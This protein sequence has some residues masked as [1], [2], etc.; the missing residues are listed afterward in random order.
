MTML[1]FAPLFR[2]T[3]AAAVACAGAI[4]L[5]LILRANL[6]PPSRLSAVDRAPLAAVA[7]QPWFVD[8]TAAA[9]IQFRHY[10]PATPMQYI[11]ETLGSGLGWID[12]NNDGWLDLFI[13]QAGPA[14]PGAAPMPALTCKL[15]RN[16]GD[17]TF[18]DVTEQ[19]GL[20]HGG[21]GLGCAVGDYDNDGW[22]DLLVTYQGGMVL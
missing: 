10:D 8:V 2:W 9:G 11:H 5:A 15:F 17:R 16:N 18:T 4:V 6:N 19:T 7:G 21:F 1:A 14:E 3:L 22:D 20:A 13:V 12:Y